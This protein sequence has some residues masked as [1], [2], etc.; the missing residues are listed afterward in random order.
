V[1]LKVQRPER[2]VDHLHRAA[3]DPR[4]SNAY[5]F[6]SLE[7]DDKVGTAFHR[8][9]SEEHGEW[10]ADERFWEDGRSL[11]F[12]QGK[13]NSEQRKIERNGLNQLMR[14]YLPRA[15]LRRA[16]SQEIVLKHQACRIGDESF[17][18]AHSA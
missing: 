1:L 12:I 2:L 8:I 16:I 5:N 17:V 18:R 4:Y 6:C 14:N 13:Q 9:W 7:L 10:R 15:Y 11:F 3:T